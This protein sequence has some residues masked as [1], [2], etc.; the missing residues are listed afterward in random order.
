MPKFLAAVAAI[1]AL[2]GCGYMQIHQDSFVENGVT[3]TP[4]PIHL[5]DY[6]G[7]ALDIGWNLAWIIR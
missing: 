5:D 2:Q 3:V 1:C 6:V 4:E 7:E